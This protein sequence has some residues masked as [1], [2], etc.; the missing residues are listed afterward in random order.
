MQNPFAHATKKAFAVARG[1]QPIEAAHDGFR[2]RFAAAMLKRRE[3][4]TNENTPR[5]VE[6]RRQTRLD[7]RFQARQ[8]VRGQSAYAKQLAADNYNRDTARAV[9]QVAANPE[10]P[11]PAMQINV[12]NNLR[13]LKIE[14]YVDFTDE[15]IR[16]PAHPRLDI[17]QK[18]YYA[19]RTMRTTM[20]ERNFLTAR[21]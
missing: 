5:P 11:Y 19:A 17:E 3:V 8:R 7:E 1:E 18:R 10:P 20:S 6:K 14:P 21:G 4:K 16:T 13:R 12:R 2:A 15:E 9:M